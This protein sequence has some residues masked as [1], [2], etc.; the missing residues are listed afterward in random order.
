MT[1][2]RR[3]QAVYSYI[4]Q[5]GTLVQSTV[6]I[7]IEYR[8]VVRLACASWTYAVKKYLLGNW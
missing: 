5:D 8:G 1:I 4:A 2:R 7:I 6:P 3:K